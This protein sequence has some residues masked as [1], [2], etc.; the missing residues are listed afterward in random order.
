MLRLATTH[1]RPDGSLTRR[2]WLRVGG[3]M[4]LTG[5]AT[6]TRGEAKGRGVG[7]GDSS[8]FGRAKSVIVIVA[9]GGQSQFETWDPKPDAPAEVRGEFGAIASAIPGVFLG[10]HLPELARL[11]DRYTI[12]RSVT[13]DDLDHGSAL[14]LS[15]TGRFHPQKSANPAPEPRRFPDPRLRADPDPA[16]PGLPL[17]GGPRQR[18]GPGP[19]APRPRAGRGLPRPRARPDGRGRRHPR[20]ELPPQPG[21]AARAPSRP[22]GRP[23]LAAP[24]GRRL[25]EPVARRPGDARDGWDLRPGLPPAR[26]ASPAAP[27]ST[28][29]PSPP[30]SATATAGT[31]RARPA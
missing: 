13:H 5:L 25:P 3:L 26:F 30:R 1:V 22:P 9:N 12:V 27:P 29:T 7:R 14:Y 31:A 23:A 28:W 8:G 6:P 20:P 10:E 17:H 18:P 21:A 15:L 19:R 24:R 16:G 4:G 2:E 11:A